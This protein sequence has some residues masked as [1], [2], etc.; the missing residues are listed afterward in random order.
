[1]EKTNFFKRIH[2][3]VFALDWNSD[4]SWKLCQDPA[5]SI[6]EILAVFLNLASRADIII[7]L[8]FP[9]QCPLSVLK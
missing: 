2:Q 6:W 5:K 4:L 9:K 1:M 3:K 8:Y 7:T